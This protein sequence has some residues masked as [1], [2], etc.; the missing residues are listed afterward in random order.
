VR[1]RSHDQHMS[2]TPMM[3]VLIAVIAGNVVIVVQ[4]AR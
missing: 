4:E 3:A 1:R 2:D